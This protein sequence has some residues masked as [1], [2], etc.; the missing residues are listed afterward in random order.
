MEKSTRA[1]SFVGDFTSFLLTAL[2]GMQLTSPILFHECS[3][4]GEGS[5]QLGVYQKFY[6]NL[7]TIGP[8]FAVVMVGIV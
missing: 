8:I 4:K 1:Q 2:R 5:L 7:G 6:V 3:K